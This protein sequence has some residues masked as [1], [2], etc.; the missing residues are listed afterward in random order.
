MIRHH[1]LECLSTVH[2]TKASPYTLVFMSPVWQECRSNANL[3][4]CMRIVP[5]P[6]FP[7]LSLV[8]FSPMSSSNT[9]LCYFSFIFF[10]FLHLCILKTASTSNHYNYTLKQWSVEGYRSVLFTEHGN[11]ISLVIIGIC[12]KKVHTHF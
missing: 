8:F 10:P 1:M 6:I 2:L 5:T 11:V 3:M 7:C 9:R 4:Q 12:M